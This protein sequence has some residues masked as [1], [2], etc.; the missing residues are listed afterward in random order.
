M[1]KGAVEVVLIEDNEYDLELAL[2]V[3]NRSGVGTG[4]VVLRDGVEAL[5]YFGCD[6]HSPQREGEA[7]AENTAL[8]ALPRLVLLDLKLPRV[9]GLEVL[10]R[11]KRSPRTAHVPVVAFTSSRQASDVRTAYELGVNSYVV[12]P[13]PFEEYADALKVPGAVGAN[14]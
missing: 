5:K 9:D 12:K 6:E 8:G 4:V 11:L 2:N 1:G 13:V 10:S 14:D 3:L 7:R